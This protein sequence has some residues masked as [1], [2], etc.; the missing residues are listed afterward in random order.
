MPK[1]TSEKRKEHILEAVLPVFADKGFQGATTKELAKAAQVSEALIYKHFPSKE[2]LYEGIQDH[3][4]TEVQGMA[5]FLS[6][7]KASSELFVV[8]LYF[9]VKSILK[10]DLLDP[11][12]HKIL[13][14]MM[15]HSINEDGEFIRHFFQVSLEP[16]LPYFKKFLIAAKDAGETVDD[17]K[18]DNLMVWFPHHLCMAINLLTLPEKPIVDYKKSE[19]ELMNQV[20]LFSL[21]G[22]GL[23]ENVIKKYNKQKNIEKYIL[24]LT[25]VS[26]G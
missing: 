9:L 11:H 16:W 20:V 24:R 8:S 2:A 17:L 25:N 1:L 23:K 3:C 14:R 18:V 10:G 21:R 13:K 6:E 7:Q 22:V 26:R 15:A 5:Q 19:D 12:K 4:C